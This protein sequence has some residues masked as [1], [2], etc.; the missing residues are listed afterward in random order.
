[1]VGELTRALERIGLDMRVAALV[2]S[3]FSTV[4]ALSGLL[5]WH[6]TE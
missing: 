5:S 6:P 3:L 1:M 2:S 4:S